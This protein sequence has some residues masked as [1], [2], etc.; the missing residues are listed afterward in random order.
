MEIRHSTEA[1]FDRIMEIYEYARKFMAETGNPIQWGA[2]N[3][4]PAQLIRQDIAAG[5]SYVCVHDDRIVGTF[6]FNTGV[7]VE[8]V[9]RTIEDG[10]W[11]DDGA[12]GVAHRIASDGSVKGTGKFCLDWAYEQCGHLR[13]DTH[14]DN[15]VMQSLLKKLG[16]THRG[17]IHVEEDNEPRLAFEK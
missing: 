1:D 4:P 11:Q 3:W 2:T 8:P 15:R 9:Y 7:D 13:I 16:F 14:G 6:F 17:T 5:K 10:S 12:Y